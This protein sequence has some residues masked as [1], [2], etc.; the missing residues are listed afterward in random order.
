MTDTSTRF[1]PRL[2]IGLAGAALLALVL[3]GWHAQT[4]LIV[5]SS[6][7]MF[8][9]CLASAA[10]L[11][12]GRA[13]LLLAALALAAGWCA[14]QMGATH[15]WFF[16]SYHYTD[17]LGPRLGAVPVVIP[18]MWFALSYTGYVMANLIVWQTPADGA[19]SIA[20]SAAQAFL[21]ALVVT[22][23]DLGVDPYMV[24]K[25]KAWIMDKRD[26][27]WFGETVQGFAGWMLVAFAIVF[28]FRLLQRRLPP[29]A[30]APSLRAATAPLLLYAG[31]MLYE[32]TQGVPVETRTIAL[33]VMGIPLFC[34]GCGL[35]RWRSER[36]PAVRFA[37]VRQEAA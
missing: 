36:R 14:E 29:T 8:A 27:W 1:L 30:A 32:A 17:V 2:A 34:A 16:G 4:W 22:A 19:T 24:Y 26:G 35:A 12:G 9:G 31:L 6:L 13:A 37:A 5:A 21:A 10:H 33:F 23:Y 28:A 18:L 7:L 25:L 20:R 11:L 3:R 15:G